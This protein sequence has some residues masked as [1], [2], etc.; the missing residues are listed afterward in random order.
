MT[1]RPLNE[2]NE[3][4]QFIKY[5]VKTEQLFKSSI[6]YSKNPSTRASIILSPSI[7]SN[8]IFF[9]HHKRDIALQIRSIISNIMITLVFIMN[10]SL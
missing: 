6:Y 2:N 7:S 5:L 4:K 9:G 8:L 10:M 1:L 3:M